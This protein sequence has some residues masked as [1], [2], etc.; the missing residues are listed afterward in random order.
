MCV[1]VCGSAVFVRKN[2]PLVRYAVLGAN[3]HPVDLPSDTN[4]RIRITTPTPASTVSA[5]TRGR[6]ANL[7][8]HSRRL[9]IKAVNGYLGGGGKGGESDLVER[10]VK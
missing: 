8:V 3:A 7:L 2:V 6:C 1:R 10:A 9:M 4:K 5:T